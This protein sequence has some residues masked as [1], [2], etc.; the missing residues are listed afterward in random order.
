M[1]S[2][3][4]KILELNQYQKS[5][6]APFVIYA[7]LRCIIEKIY[8]CKNNPDNSSTANV[9]EHI[10]EGFSSL[11]YLHLEAEKISMMYTDV[12]IV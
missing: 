7:D 8:G 5:D 4:T 1:P 3:D 6:K 9:S 11:E 12:K 10:P 2:Q